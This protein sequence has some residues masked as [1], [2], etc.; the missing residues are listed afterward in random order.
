VNVRAVFAA[1][2]IV[3][4]AGVWV[5]RLDRQGVANLRSCGEIEPGGRRFDLVQSLGAPNASEMNPA[6][7]RLVLSFRS[8][9]F[10]A[11]PIRA[12]VNVRD[13]M[14]IEIDCGDGRLRTYDKY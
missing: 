7:T 10:A 4:M 14:V 8:V 6:G 2:I 12:V 13:D 3:L 9:L 1:L 11:R 5:Y